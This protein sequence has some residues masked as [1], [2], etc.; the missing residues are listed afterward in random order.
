MG[1]ILKIGLI[2]AG[3]GGITAAV[4]L[5]QRGFKVVVY[6]Q[7]SGL[8]EIGA[9]ITVGPNANRVINGLGLETE[10]EALASA[11]P[12]VGVLDYQTGERL[13]Y[14]P[15][16]H[17]AYMR[18]HGAVS[19]LMHRAD[20]HAALERAFNAD[21]YSLRLNH[22]LTEIAQDDDGVTLQ[23]ANGETDRCDVAI[24]C[25]GLKS[26]IRDKM[27][28]T[29]P[30]VFTGYVAWRGLVDRS[31]VPDVSLDPH[32][33]AYPA[34]NKMFARYP[35]RHGTLINYVAN[36]RRSG[37]TSESWKDQTDISE[38][39]E[40]FDGWCDD[41]VSII[42]ATPG[43]LCHRWA[44][45]SRVPLDSWI[46]GRVSLLGDA[47]H[48]MT[49]FHGMGAGMAIEDAAVLA[50]CFEASGNDWQGALQRYERAR[51]TRAN[52]FHVASLD[53]G[54]TYMSSKPDD[55]KQSPS[56]GVEDELGYDAMSVTI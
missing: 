47:A 36:A 20:V 51:L 29:E 5:Q 24:A 55:R 31:L 32:F 46:N 14:I 28:P 6:E 21:E 49:P 54:K 38:V 56:A 48:P 27:F 7:S 53:R 12:H 10:F 8:G 33:A 16:G 23:F 18:D 40:E 2:G 30:P 3:I 15:R 50:R 45:H 44:L 25:D 9:G 43:G 52:K 19:R 1:Q 22:K 11:S 26:T 41:V 17:D 35:V 37:H 13:N 39:V 42:R 34:E 4:A